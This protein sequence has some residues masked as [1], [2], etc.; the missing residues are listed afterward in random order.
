MSPFAGISFVNNS[1]N[2][3]EI[4]QLIDIEL[5]EIVVL[6]KAI[7]T[8]HHNMASRGCVKH[9]IADNAIIAGQSDAG[10]EHVPEI[11]VTVPL[12]D[13]DPA[14]AFPRPFGA[15]IFHRPNARN[16]DNASAIRQGNHKLYVSWKEGGSLDA[17]GIASRPCTTL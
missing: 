7:L 11:A 5:V 3:T 8:S 17:S 13:N 12:L 16:G 6:D 14:T 9:G 4:S 2:E 15:L 10:A 1:F